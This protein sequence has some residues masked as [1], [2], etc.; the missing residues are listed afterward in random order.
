MVEKPIEWRRFERVELEGEVAHAAPRATGVSPVSS[1]PSLLKEFERVLRENER[2][3]LEVST[4]R[5]EAAR[6]GNGAA[7]YRAE[8]E[9]ARE[10]LAQLE[11][12]ATSA[13]V[14][15]P[16]TPSAAHTSASAEQAAGPS[17]DGLAAVAGVV[18]G[19]L[20]TNPT[21]ANVR[22]VQDALL[23]RGVGSIISGGRSGD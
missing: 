4:L 3:H 17:T 11:G 18:A 21:G 7:K 22:L 15:T 19:Y 14:G 5:A 8:L 12:D 2:L 6:T 10:E 16:E 9:S 20:F 1:P 23:N 13:P